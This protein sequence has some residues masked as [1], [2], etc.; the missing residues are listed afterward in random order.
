MKGYGLYKFCYILKTV[1]RHFF[2]CRR[3]LEIF[4]FFRWKQLAMVTV[5]YFI[6]VFLFALMGVHI[7]GGLNY[8]C[9]HK[10]LQEDGSYMYAKYFMLIT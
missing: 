9:V 7:I 4:F 8:A 2:N 10:M 3:N 6:F 1:F 5:F